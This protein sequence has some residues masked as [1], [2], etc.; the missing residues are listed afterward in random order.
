MLVPQVYQYIVQIHSQFN[1]HLV[2]HLFYTFH[3][4]LLAS[5]SFILLYIMFRS[6][7]MER[8]VGEM[9]GLYL[10]HLDTNRGREM[11]AREL[12]ERFP[13]QLLQNTS[14]QFWNDLEGNTK[15]S[16]PFSS[17]SLPSP[18]LFFLLKML[19][20]HNVSQLRY[21]NPRT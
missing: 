13:S 20:K 17:P 4:I 12:K 1:G 2:L 9:K 8:K 16:P 14:F 7:K 5:R 11:E 21:Q 3:F 10:Y 18:T 19:S 6:E 15:I